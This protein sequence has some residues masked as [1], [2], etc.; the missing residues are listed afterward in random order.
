VVC[1]TC[2][3]PCLGCAADSLRRML[4]GLSLRWR[5]ALLHLS[6]RETASPQTTMGIRNDVWRLWR[7]PMRWRQPLRFFL[8]GGLRHR[9]RRYCPGKAT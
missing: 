3:R 6:L 9:R 1:E 5:L 2:L 8:G 4:Q 7:R